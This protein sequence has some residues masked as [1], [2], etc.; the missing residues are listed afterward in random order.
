MLAE[1]RAEIV[2][3]ALA[4]TGG[5]RLRVAHTTSFSFDMS[6]DELFWLLDGHELHLCDEQLR[7]DAHRLVEHC[8]AQRLDVLNVTP[9][10]A[11]A[12]L[13]AGLLDAGLLDGEHVPSLVL[14]GGEAAT[15]SV[16]TALR[17]APRTDGYNLY[18]PTEFSVNALGGGVTDSPTPTVGRPV[19]NTRVHILDSALRPV[20]DGSPGELYLAGAGL[21]RGYHDRAGLTAENFVAD[22]YAAEPGRRMY[23]TGD[24]AR[25]RPDGTIDFLGRTDDQVKI[26]GYRIEPGEIVAA[27]EAHPL[28]AQAAVV[29]DSTS[30]RGG[31][32]V[33]RLAAYLVPADP[34]TGAPAAA[35]RGHLALHLPAHMVPASIVSLDELPLTANGKLDVKALPAPVYTGGGN[36]PP[37]TGPERTLCALFAELLDAADVGADDDFFALGGDSISSV[38]L[39]GRARERGLVLTPRQV[40]TSRT[41][42]ALALVATIEDTPEQPRP[43]VGPLELAPRDLAAKSKPVRSAVATSTRRRR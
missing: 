18:G 10:Y 33:A 15:D 34:R 17:E 27:L 9:T 14:L 37:R 41:P 16:W 20:L 32:A 25:R 35:I 29:V 19:H 12:L 8:R 1:Y 3:R 26:R 30:S 21:A 39:V 38:T 11:R 5:R 40:F 24:L 28:V 31:P 7:R 6:W 43:P 23:R 13:D 4:G 36:R 2:P 22:P 42:E